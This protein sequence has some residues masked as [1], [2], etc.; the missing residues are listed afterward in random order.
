[1]IEDN[2]DGREALVLALR[3]LGHEVHAAN[4][5]RAGIELVHQTQPDW[6]LVD[7]GLPDIGGYDVARMLRTVSGSGSKLIA[8]TGYGV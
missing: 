1:V 2:D 7:I 6:G 8:L 4:T 5:G 3:T